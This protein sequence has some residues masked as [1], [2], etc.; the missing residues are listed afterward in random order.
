[1]HYSGIPTPQFMP[2]FY[3][4]FRTLSD[5]LPNVLIINGAQGFDADVGTHVVPAFD[6]KIAPPVIK[7]QNPSAYK[8]PFPPHGFGFK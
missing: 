4:D 6:V 2:Q 8:S 5:Q 7:Y 1:M 3:V